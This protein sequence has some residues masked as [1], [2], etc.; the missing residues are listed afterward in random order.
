MSRL[1]LNLSREGVLMK[2]FVRIL[3][4]TLITLPSAVFVQAQTS[5]MPASSSAA[6]PT[7]RTD[8]YRVFFGKSAAGKAAQMAEMLKMPDP[9]SPMPGHVLL[10]RHQE[11]DSWDYALIEHLGT[12]ATVDAM[13][14]QVPANMRDVTDWHN[15]TFVNGPSWAE[16][17]RAMGISD[18]AAKSGGSVYIVSVFRPAPGHRDQ[19][20][21]MLSAPPS[22]AN[23][24]TSAGNVLMQH[25]EG[26]PWT[27]LTITR[28]NSWQDVATYE[29]AGAGQTAKNQGGWFQM[30]D[31]L[32]FHTDT[33]ATRVAP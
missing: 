21:K 7:A 3:A 9:K 22:R 14:F 33:L 19:L 6:S 2:S 28:Y 24:D 17:S 8:V 32:A 23:G 13:P 18:D 20:E 5:P 31:H 29:T 16:F 4:V 30:R 25:L 1:Q 26:S 15:D 10:L 27:F 11:G 12:K